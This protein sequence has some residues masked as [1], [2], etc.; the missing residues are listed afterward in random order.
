[1]SAPQ[2]FLRGYSSQQ[3][4]TDLDHFINYVCQVLK[5][6]VR[7]GETVILRHLVTSGVLTGQEVH[8]RRRL[9]GSTEDQPRISGVVSPQGTVTCTCRK[10][11]RR[12][13]KITGPLTLAAFAEHA[14]IPPKQA[15]SAMLSR[16]KVSL[17]DV[18]ERVNERLSGK[19]LA[20]PAAVAK[21]PAAA[22]QEGSVGT[23]LAGRE[24]EEQSSGAEGLENR[25]GRQ[26]SCDDSL[27]GTVGILLAMKARGA[28][29][30]SVA[31]ASN[32]GAAGEAAARHSHQ[33]QSGLEVLA[34]ELRL[35]GDAAVRPQFTEAPP[36]LR[37]E[38]GNDLEAE[39]SDIDPG[40]GWEGASEVGDGSSGD[41]EPPGAAA[42]AAAA[43]SQG[44][45][46]AGRDAMEVL[47]ALAK[48]AAAWQPKQRRGDDL[49]RGQ[50]A[51]MEP[52]G[53]GPP[54]E[55]PFLQQQPVQQQLL[56]G[57][58]AQQQQQQQQQVAKQKGQAAAEQHY[59][60][61]HDESEESGEDITLGVAGLAALKASVAP[62]HGSSGVQL[63]PGMGVGERLVAGS[64]ACLWRGLHSCSAAGRSDQQMFH[65]LLPRYQQHVPAL[66]HQLKL[67]PDTQ[68]LAAAL[69]ALWASGH[70]SKLAAIPGLWPGGRQPLSTS[71]QSAA[72]TAAHSHGGSGETVP[73]QQHAVLEAAAAAAAL[74]GWIDHGSGGSGGVGDG[75]A[76][77]AWELAGLDE[78]SEQQ[79]GSSM[80]RGRWQHKGQSQEHD[81]PG[82]VGEGRRPARATRQ[83]AA[84]VASAP[85]QEHWR[86]QQ[87]QPQQQQQRAGQDAR[88]GQA[89][90]STARRRWSQHRRLS[91]R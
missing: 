62:L 19:G 23:R 24:V 68:Q 82:L 48:A 37:V 32:P 30:V 73:G 33:A 29:G 72:A 51:G 50:E 16:Y 91:A 86:R 49:Q 83:A 59:Q 15:A 90:A 17:K 9:R 52:E 35:A 41:E 22:G 75:S 88:G 64:L 26:H 14:G 85:Q 8:L 70:L 7:V 71:A 69:Q 63:P 55:G 34:R 42:A 79:P 45:P 18:L 40:C 78:A 27:P 74:G 58:K 56:Q 38:E 60:L 80:P 87:Q 10:C 25:Q 89:P 11:K 44:K 84:G 12:P 66:M 46:A 61:D 28:Q 31:A 77:Q 20:G 13:N 65:S 1:M 2:S 67:L 47:S 5:L 3:N 54:L 81:L 21:E 57:R 4:P 6:L 36:A 39:T 53:L 43:K 76:A